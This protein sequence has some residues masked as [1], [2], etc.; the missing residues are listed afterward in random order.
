MATAM[1]LR[2]VPS[3]FLYGEAPRDAGE[4]ALHVEPIEFRSARNHWKIQPHVHR[5]LHQLIFVLRGHGVSVAEGAIVQYA[6]PALIVV[7]AGTV[8][9]FEFEPGTHG[10]VVSMTDDLLREIAQRDPRAAALFER[11]ATLEL[12]AEALRAT[13]LA[14]AFKM[15]TREF[16]STL[17]GHSLALEGLLKV[18]L[19]NVLRLPHGSVE[20]AEAAASRHRWLVRRFREL[21]ETAFRE[22]WCLADYAA[23]LSVSQSRLRNACVSVTEHSPMQIVHARVV[24][25][26]KRQL[27]YTSQS[28]CEIAYALGFDDPAYFTRFFSQR[29]GFSPRTFRSRLAQQHGEGEGAF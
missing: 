23:A 6:P 8:H 28:V 1:P 9:G 10:F 17:P 7:P 4:P 25:E 2:G 15:L 18:V 14:L 13:D 26:A 19:A 21:I 29:T 24:L 3:F 22:G 5:T 20:S 16:G 12:P 27:R 11:S